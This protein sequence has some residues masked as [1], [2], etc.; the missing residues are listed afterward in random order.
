MADF[1]QRC[2]FAA[3]TSPLY[4]TCVPYSIRIP[5]CVCVILHP[6]AL[7]NEVSNGNHTECVVCALARWQ[8]RA[9]RKTFQLF[10]ALHDARGTDSH[11]KQ[12]RL[13]KNWIS[14]SVFKIFISAARAGLKWGGF[15]A[16][17]RG[18]GAPSRWF[19][20]LW[21]RHTTTWP[22]FRRLSYLMS[23]YSNRTQH[24]WEN[25]T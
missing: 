5:F 3:F 4:Y 14:A 18:S 25:E 21:Y 11:T 10:C 12:Q 23:R 16:V 8:I 22:C 6:E 7:R 15:C 13:I 24:L 2:I 17:I 20:Q 9:G 1:S 19:P